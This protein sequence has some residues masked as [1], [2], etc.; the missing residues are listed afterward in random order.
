MSAVWALVR[1]RLRQDRLQ[2]SLWAASIALLTWVAPIAVAQSYGTLADRSSLLQTVAVNPVILLF[3][4]LPSG[5]EEAAFTQFLILPWI[6]VLAAFLCLFLAVRHTRGDEE[7]G[8]LDLV[9]ATPAGRT[10]PLNATLIEGGLAAGGVGA[11]VAIVLLAL[12]SD[13]AGSLLTGAV[14][15]AAGLMFLAVGLVSAQLMRSSRGANALGVWVLLL[16]FLLAGIGNALGT[17]SPDLQRFESS[18]LAWLSPFG[19]L[20]QARPFADNSWWPAVVGVACAILLTVIAYA[21]HAARDAGGSIVAPRLGR[22]RAGHSLGSSW[23]LAWR[24]TR[25]S[26]LGWC[27]GAVITGV[28]ATSLGSIVAQ[29]GNQVPAVQQLLKAMSGDSTLERGMVVLFMLIGGVLASCFAVQT[30]V[31]ARHEEALGRAGMVCSAGVHRVVWLASYLGVALGGVLVIVVSLVVGAMLGAARAGNGSLLLDAVA[32]AAGQ[33]AA[34]AV[35][36]TLTALVWVLAPRLTVVFG[37]ALVLVALILGLYAPL[38]GAP[39]WVEQ[40]SPFAL[41]PIP[42]SG[43]VDTRGLVWLVLTTVLAG[44]GALLLMRRRELTADT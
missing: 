30:V 6:A 16:T 44:T 20:E 19:L 11:L 35:F 14:C 37:W 28:L 22:M 18:W 9:G 33:A 17:P 13:A 32:A 25:G 39:S 26:L 40:L 41:T 31:H 4:G 27:L 36:A 3:R 38:F 2:L 8:R 12:G 29:L 23:G 7:Q 21:L 15:A 34:G 5:A 42:T 24:L 10:A 43:G 1:L